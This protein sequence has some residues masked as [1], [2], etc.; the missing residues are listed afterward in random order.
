MLDLTRLEND[1]FVPVNS[2]ALPV[3]ITRLHDVTKNVHVQCGCFLGVML[4]GLDH[5]IS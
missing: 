1:K 4:N 3:Y 2:E 5:K